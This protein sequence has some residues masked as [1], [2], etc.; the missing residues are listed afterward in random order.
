MPVISTNFNASVD[1][2]KRALS[3][4]DT[5]AFGTQLTEPDICTLEMFKLPSVIII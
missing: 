3:K 4:L 5:F 2:L 1:E